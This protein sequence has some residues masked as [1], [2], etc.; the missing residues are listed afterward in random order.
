MRLSPMKKQD[1]LWIEEMAYVPSRP[2]VAP[3]G[4]ELSTIPMRRGHYKRGS[5]N[6]VWEE[7]DMSLSQVLT[8]SNGM[9]YVC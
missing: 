9:I 3:V 2:Q 1:W 6:A 7:F 4:G 8:R 5:L